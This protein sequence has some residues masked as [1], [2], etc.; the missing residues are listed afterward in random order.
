M[1]KEFPQIWKTILAS[2]DGG[3]KTIPQ[4]AEELNINKDIV[5]YHMM[6]MNK[7]SVVMAD[8]MDEKEAYYYYKRKY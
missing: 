5:T 8:G 6:T 3:K 4:I 7:Y 1:M 2:I